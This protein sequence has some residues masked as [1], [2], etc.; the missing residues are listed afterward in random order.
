MTSKLINPLKE[1]QKRLEIALE[2]AEKIVVPEEE[3]EQ[4]KEFAKKWEDD[5]RK[6]GL[7]Y[8]Q[9]GN[10]LTSRSLTGHAGQI[11]LEHYLGQRFT[12]LDPKF[13]YD[14]N[15]PDLQPLGLRFGVKTHR[16]R[17]P[18]LVNYISEKH[19]NNLSE[20]SKMHYRYPQIILT[21]DNDCDRTFYLLGL[22]SV[23]MLYHP[24]YLCPELIYDAD[25]AERGT[26]MPF[27][28]VHRGHHFKTV[29]DLYGYA[30]DKW[31]IEMNKAA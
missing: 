19:Y 12:D 17:N 6:V 1:Y 8:A 16:Q 2:S 14:K 23:T 5:K 11:A 15:V 4:I 31:T 10:L 29:E 22:F 26:K 13:G 9:D 3:Y 27:I 24:D 30:K 20:E 18:P 7:H 21:R 25:L 28:G